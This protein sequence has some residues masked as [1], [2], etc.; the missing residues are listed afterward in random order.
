MSLGKRPDFRR[1]PVEDAGN[2]LA[3]MPGVRPGIGSIRR[4]SP[5]DPVHE[6]YA[7]GITPV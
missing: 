3:V 4:D 6:E 7:I 1:S 2:V 5:L